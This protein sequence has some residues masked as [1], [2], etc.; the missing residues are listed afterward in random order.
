MSPVSF[1]DPSPVLRDV[2]SAEVIRRAKRLEL[3]RLSRGDDAFPVTGIG[4]R[5]GGS[6]NGRGR[7]WS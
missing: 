4:W 2:A 1:C 5:V 7:R 6:S 3:E